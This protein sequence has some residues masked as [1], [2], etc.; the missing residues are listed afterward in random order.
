MHVPTA[1]HFAILE[2]PQA[3]SVVEVGWP[4]TAGIGGVCSE[5]DENVTM[6]QQPN[7]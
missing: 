4:A 6:E 1:S 2:V 3:W 7:T 5:L